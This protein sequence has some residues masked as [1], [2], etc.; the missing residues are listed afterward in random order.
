MKR[1]ELILNSIFLKNRILE[2]GIK[3]WWL[4]EQIGVDRK[5]VIRWVQG[6]V[7][8]IQHENAEALAQI[9]NCKVE[10]L[11]LSDEAEQLATCSRCLRKIGGLCGTG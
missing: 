10:D 2:L 9:L 5:T 11:S 1:K 7:R 4:A 8:S 6:Q 3:Q